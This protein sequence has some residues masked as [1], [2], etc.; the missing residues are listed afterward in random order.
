MMVVLAAVM[1]RAIADSVVAYQQ[2]VRV[3]DETVMKG[4][5]R[6]PTR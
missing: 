5:A 4:A 2:Q 3:I 6:P 1:M